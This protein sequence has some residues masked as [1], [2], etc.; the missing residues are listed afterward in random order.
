MDNRECGR[1]GGRR[2][3]HGLDAVTRAEALFV[4]CVDMERV[5]HRHA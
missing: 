1:D 2:G 4:R 3:H 5:C